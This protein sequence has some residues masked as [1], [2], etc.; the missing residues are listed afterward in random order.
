MELDNEALS[1]EVRNND[2]K[3][4]IDILKPPCVYQVPFFY[5]KRMTIG[6]KLL[7]V[8]PLWR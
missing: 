1:S 2:I 7:K 3:Q 5:K 4:I 8:N 6:F